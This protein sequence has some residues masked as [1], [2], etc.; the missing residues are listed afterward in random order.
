MSSSDRRP[1]TLERLSM[2]APLWIASLAVLSLSACA[3]DDSHPADPAPLTPTERYSIEVKPAPDEVQLAAHASGLSDAQVAALTDLVARWSGGTRGQL[4]IKA[5]EHGPDP[6]G[7]YR[8]ATDARDFLIAQG[9]QASDVHIV[10]YDAQGDAHAP[11]RVGFMHYVAQGPQCGQSWSNL[12]DV[13]SNREYDEFGCAVT[14][15]V[16]AELA[17]PEDLLHPRAMTGPDAGRRETVITKYRTGDNT[18][19]TRDSQANGAVS[20]VVGQ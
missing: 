6:S 11:V 17:S 8:T 15:N 12:A 20:T 2:R 5:P 7:V 4:T 16:A 1:L 10:G 19:T 14:A 3:T 18:S 13:R 9:I